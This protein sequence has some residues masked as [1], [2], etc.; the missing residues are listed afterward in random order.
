MYH[1]ELYSLIY[2]VKEKHGPRSLVSHV[3]K[4]TV[5]KCT[6]QPC[7]PQ[8]MPHGLVMNPCS[9]VLPKSQTLKSQ[10]K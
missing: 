10:A 2:D 6:L 9:Q 1:S 7:K 5:F 4:D 8:L 3:K